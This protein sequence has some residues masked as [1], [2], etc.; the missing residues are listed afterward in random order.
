[1]ESFEKFEKTELPSKNKFYSKISMKGI[2][3]NDHERSKFGIPWRKGPNVAI[4]TPSW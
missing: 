4:M 2:S 3:E 1:M